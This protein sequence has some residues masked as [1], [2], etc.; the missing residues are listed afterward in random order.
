MDGPG[1][2]V[3]RSWEMK[4]K[5]VPSWRSFSDDTKSEN[6]KVTKKKIHRDKRKGSSQVRS[7]IRRN[8]YYVG[9]WHGWSRFGETSFE[10][11]FD[12]GTN[13]ESTYH[14]NSVLLWTII[15]SH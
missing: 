15:E 7:T 1:V 6:L 3:R 9:N 5:E 13:L 12:L 11:R 4:E 2:G 10:L 8:T 14:F